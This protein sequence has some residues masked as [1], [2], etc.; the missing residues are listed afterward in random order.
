MEKESETMKDDL[1]PKFI[2]SGTHTDLLVQVVK[3]KIDLMKLAREQLADRGVDE[4]GL[5]VGFDEAKIIH[6]GK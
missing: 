6:I 1:N 5:W 2:F 4:N 3:G